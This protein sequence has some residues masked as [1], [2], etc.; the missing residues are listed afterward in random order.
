MKLINYNYGYSDFFNCSVHGKII[1]T[2][3][4]FKKCIDYLK[5]CKPDTSYPFYKELSLNEWIKHTLKTKNATLI[6]LRVWATSKIA[7]KFNI[8]KYKKGNYLFNIL[9]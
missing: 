5:R 8:K 2:K 3:K 1:V 4:E 6:N 9:N 7:N